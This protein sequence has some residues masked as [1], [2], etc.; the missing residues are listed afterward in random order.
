MWHQKQQD[1]ERHRAAGLVPDPP[2]APEPARCPHTLD[3]PTSHWL[4]GSFLWPVSLRDTGAD[5]FACGR[6]GFCGCGRVLLTC[7]AGGCGGHLRTTACYQAC[8]MLTPQDSRPPCCI[9]L[10]AQARTWMSAC[11]H[12]CACLCALCGG[13]GSHDS[14]MPHLASDLRPT[15]RPAG[16]CRRGLCAPAP[17]AILRAL[18][19]EHVNPRTGLPGPQGADRRACEVQAHCPRPHGWPHPMS[20]CCFSPQPN[21][22]N[23]QNALVPQ[24]HS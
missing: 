1:P 9:P 20:A 17:T 15:R 11:R 16:S 14:I 19:H 24:P 22:E 4:V 13:G 7:R 8:P 5:S 10:C 21:K 6:Q 2:H 12:A 18:R 3:A 23:R